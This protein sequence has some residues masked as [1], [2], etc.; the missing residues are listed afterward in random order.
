M[1]A[2][3]CCE[4]AV[5]DGS[6][7]ML[8][9]TTPPLVWLSSAELEPLSSEVVDLVVSKLSLEPMCVVD[10]ATGPV[11]G[12]VPVTPALEVDAWA[13]EAAEIDEPASDCEDAMVESCPDDT[14]VLE[15]SAVVEETTPALVLVLSP[16][17][18]TMVCDAASVVETPVD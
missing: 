4:V 6:F 13:D 16:E 10:W 11:I 1:V 3:L 14:T 12:S 8:E 18:W 15:S 17:E 9:T 7:G 2:A 5:S